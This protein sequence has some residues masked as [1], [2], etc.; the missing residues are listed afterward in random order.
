MEPLSLALGRDRYALEAHLRPHVY[1]G[2]M[3]GKSEVGAWVG[4]GLGDPVGSLPVALGGTLLLAIPC[5][6]SLWACG[7]SLWPLWIP[8]TFLP[9][10][11]LGASYLEPS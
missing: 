10:T 8:T 11:Y 9:R 4:L 3:V 2:I 6:P 5:E 7:A 1:G